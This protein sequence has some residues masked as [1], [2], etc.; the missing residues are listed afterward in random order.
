MMMLTK[1]KCGAAMVR[2]S[3]LAVIARL[4][5][6]MLK[7]EDPIGVIVKLPKLLSIVPM[8]ATIVDA[9]I[10]PTLNSK[11]SPKEEAQST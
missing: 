11:C 9:K 1:S 2:K 6:S 4:L 7:L 5:I 3:L 10:F 8:P